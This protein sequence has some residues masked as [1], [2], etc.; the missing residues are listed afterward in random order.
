MLDYEDI[1]FNSTLHFDF[2]LP[3]KMFT[4]YEAAPKSQIF[5]NGLDTSEIRWVDEPGQGVLWYENN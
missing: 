1:L 2:N 3:V 4:S 5:F